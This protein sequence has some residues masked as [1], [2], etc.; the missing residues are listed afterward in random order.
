MRI[1]AGAV[2]AITAAACTSTYCA[3]VLY[4]S[5]QPT[6]GELGQVDSAVLA[7]AMLEVCID[8]QCSSSSLGLDGQVFI[9]GVMI[10]ALTDE[11]ATTSLVRFEL[12]VEEEW[13]AV[14][15]PAQQHSIRLSI[16]SA[17][18]PVV[19]GTWIYASETKEPDG[20]QDSCR[21]T[22]FYRSI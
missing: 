7:G 6:T 21:E 19:T 10:K 22:V 18:A 5:V 15:A 16:T 9:S 1:L 8:N 20:C 14:E 3:S 11:T 2:L 4:C 13:N 17:N 12:F